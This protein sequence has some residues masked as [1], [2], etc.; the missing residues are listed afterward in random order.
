MTGDASL[1]RP[2][3]VRLVTVVLWLLALVLGLLSIFALR[4]LVIWGA[5]ILFSGVDALSKSQS[6]GL[7]DIANYC[8]VV[9]LGLVTLV[10]IVASGEYVG[11]HAGERHL[12]RLL[13]IMIAVEGAIILPVW[14]FFWR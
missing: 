4:E 8:G 9:F 6:A 1:P 11:K 14:F 2:A 13:T 7:V 12:L 3:G 5:A 10:G